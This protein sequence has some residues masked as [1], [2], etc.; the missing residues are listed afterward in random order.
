MIKKIIVSFFIISIFHSKAQ[1]NTKFLDKY[2]KLNF[3]IGIAY[4]YG[5]K[6]STIPSSINYRYINYTSPRFGLHYDFLQIRQFN[7][8]I[9]IS[10]FLLQEIDEHYFSKE[11]TV[12]DYDIKKRY[13][14]TSGDWQ[15]NMPITVEYITYLPKS[16]LSFNASFI[17]GYQDYS[18]GETEFEIGNNNETA[19]FKGEYSRGNNA[20]HPSTQIG[21]GMYF[22]F[23]KWMLRTN[24][25]YNIMLEKM[26]EGTF[27]F[28]GLRQSPDIDGTYSFSGNSFGIEFS[29]YLAKRKK[30]Q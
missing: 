9:G 26:Y 18:Y 22:P 5:S 15:F 21:I 16:K 25:Y 23:K 7:F 29:I 2:N 11:E 28:R 24:L 1:S 8:K 19:S 6:T 27:E 20:W 10:T 14:T 4:F 3:E 17:I 13:I 12:L 30:K